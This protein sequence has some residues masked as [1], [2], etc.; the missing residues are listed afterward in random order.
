MFLLLLLTSIKL[1]TNQQVGG[2]LPESDFDSLSKI[3]NQDTLVVFC[4]DQLLNNRVMVDFEL[5][6]FIQFVLV[7]HL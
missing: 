5:K 3:P 1:E 6:L 2:S 7:L 4:T